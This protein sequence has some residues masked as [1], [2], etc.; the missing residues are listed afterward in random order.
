MQKD[1][2]IS[3]ITLWRFNDWGMYNRRDEAIL[4]ELSRR[5]IVEKVLHI[6]HIGIKVLMYRTIQW[7]KEKDALLREVYKFHVK[8]GM[9]LKPISIDNEKKYYVYSVVSLYQGNN[10]ILKEISNHFLNIQYFTINKYFSK[11]G[12]NVVLI[13]YPPSKY[14]SNAIETIRHDILIA[15]F[16]DDTAERFHDEEA[17]KNRILHNYQKILPQCNWIFSTS[18]SINQK[19]KDY[20]QQEITFLPNGADIKNFRA[21]SYKKLFKKVNKKAVGYIGILN[22]EIDFDLFEYILSRY[23]QVDFVL[24]G[25]AS[26]DQLIEINK[27]AKQYN[28]LRYLG[29]RNYRD[30]P[31]YLTAFDVLI[32]IKKNDHTTAG[33]DLQKIY[34]YLS[35]GKPI[36]TTPIPPADRFA[37]LMYVASDKFQFSE[38]LKIAL[39]EDN[40]ELREK[41]IKIALDNSWDKRVDVI[42]ERAK[43]LL[44]D[45]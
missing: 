17:A 2:K 3:F 9:S 20:A 6:E 13:A 24:I 30:I 12:E 43:A 32:N 27:L 10:P 40:K 33:A 1:S 18:P 42:L 14:L 44:A 7:V 16:E 39:E 35:S 23:P 15:D 4:W 21:N 36:V 19:Y 38:F 34:D 5:D 11:A 25:C 45:N 8:K 31:G 26:D 41:R 22:R 37:D 28:N 29:A